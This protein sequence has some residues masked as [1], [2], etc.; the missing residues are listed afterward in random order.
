MVTRRL[1]LL[2]CLLVAS[3]CQTPPQPAPNPPSHASTSAKEG[4]KQPETAPPKSAPPERTPA[5]LPGLAVIDKL[6]P[7][8][9]ERTRLT[10]EYIREHYDPAAKDISIT[11]RMVIIHW[12]G[13]SSAKGTLSAFASN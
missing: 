11:P 1:S 5:S 8:D 2:S 9:E 7:F 4:P 10:L 6:L 12:T 13:G 3:G